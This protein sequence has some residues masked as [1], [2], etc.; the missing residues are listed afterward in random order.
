[1][2]K[3]ERQERRPARAKLDPPE[4]HVFQ[5]QDHANSRRL[6]IDYAALFGAI[7]GG[8]A[9]RLFKCIAAL[10]GALTAASCSAW[11]CNLQTWIPPNR[12][13]CVGTA[14]SR[15][16]IP[17]FRLFC[18]IYIRTY[19]NVVGVEA[20]KRRA[21]GVGEELNKTKHTFA[22]GGTAWY[23]RAAQRGYNSETSRTGHVPTL[24]PPARESYGREPLGA[25]SRAFNIS[26]G[27][28]APKR[29]HRGASM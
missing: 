26:D 23:R 17:C 8:D 16:G 20:N 18:A 27:S 28:P 4:A 15:S 2:R 11:S 25:R 13:S 5:K 10:H 14:V 7:S 22:T 1:M 6:C 19:R 24:T 3:S 9:S 21:F 29:K 12:A